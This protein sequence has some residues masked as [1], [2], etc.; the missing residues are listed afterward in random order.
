MDLTGKILPDTAIKELFADNAITSEQQLDN[1]QIQPASIDLRLGSC[2]YRLR[3]SFLPG[4]ENSV[5]DMLQP[6]LVMHKIDLTKGA[7]LETGCIYLVPLLEALRLPPNISGRANP[8]SSTGRIDVFT[9]VICDNGISFDT[10][11]AGYNGPLW[12]EICPRT[13]SILARTGDRLAQLRLRA[14]QAIKEK[15]QQTLTVSIS[16][17]KTGLAGYRAKRHSGVL[18]LSGIA[19]HSQADYWEPLTTRQGSLILDPGEFYIL[20][21]K[22]DIVI[23]ANMAAEMAPTATDIGEFRVHYAGFFDPGFGATGVASKAVLEIRGRDVPFLLTDGQ[24][25]ARLVFEPMQSQPETLYGSNTSH[26]Q[27][28]GLKLSKLFKP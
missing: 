3:A 1:D 14:Q 20:A 8:K 28:Q 4:S 6:P 25:I 23:P 12:I 16:L 17:P 18:D 10:V 22:E 21:S 7:V 9:R 15:D 24:D 5:A 13:F 27:G 26:Y 2:A 19:S 11:K